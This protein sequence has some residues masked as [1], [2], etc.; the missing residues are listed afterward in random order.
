M[1]FASDSTLRRIGPVQTSNRPMEWS[2][3]PLNRHEV[4]HLE[5]LWP[6]LPP[7]I[8]F[9]HG[10]CNRFLL[11]RLR[12]RLSNIVEYHKDHP[13]QSLQSR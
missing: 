8:E 12:K 1:E 2:C 9:D 4:M 7:S 11:I 13:F 5:N 3:Q 10:F 6:V